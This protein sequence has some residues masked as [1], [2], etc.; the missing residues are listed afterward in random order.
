MFVTGTMMFFS[1]YF[2]L[3]ILDMLIWYW[4][5][6]WQVQHRQGDSEKSFIRTVQ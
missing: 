5:T 1:E 2:F 3:L 4:F 6:R